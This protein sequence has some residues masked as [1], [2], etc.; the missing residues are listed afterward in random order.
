MTARFGR[1]LLAWT[2][3]LG[4]ALV[5]VAFLIATGELIGHAEIASPLTQAVEPDV[6]HAKPGEDLAVDDT[7]HHPGLAVWPAR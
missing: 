2:I 1:K 7:Y 4:L 5:L 6:V 3:A